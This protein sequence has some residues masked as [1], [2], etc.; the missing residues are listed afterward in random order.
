MC[1]CYPLTMRWVAELHAET[2][3]WRRNTV[4]EVIEWRKHLINIW[5]TV[6]KNII[7]KGSCHRQRNYSLKFHNALWF[8]AY[9]IPY[10][11]E[12]G[13]Q[14]QMHCLLCKGTTKAVAKAWK[15]RNVTFIHT[16]VQ[17]G[18]L[19]KCWKADD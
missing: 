4:I 14:R 13:Q 12:L 9:N 17:T 7:L 6:R 18:S 1:S 3:R 10:A 8:V 15:Q 11:Q 2:E 5:H 19:T 16:K